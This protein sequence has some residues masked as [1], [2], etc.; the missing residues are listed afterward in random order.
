MESIKLLLN[1]SGK[2]QPELANVGDKA[3]SRWTADVLSD[4]KYIPFVTVGRHSGFWDRHPLSSETRPASLGPRGHSCARSPRAH[5]TGTGQPRR[6]RPPAAPAPAAGAPRLGQTMLNP[7]ATTSAAAQ[8]G[9][10]EQHITGAVSKTSSRSG[11][12]SA[13]PQLSSRRGE[14][15]LCARASG[16]A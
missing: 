13:P 14:N 6:H 3:L 12:F 15:V 8:A 5:G 16:K 4:A 9:Q 7:L 1:S 10:R 11:Y 2:L